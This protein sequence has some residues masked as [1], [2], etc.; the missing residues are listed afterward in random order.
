M[1]YESFSFVGVESSLTYLHCDVLVCDGSASLT[2]DNRCTRGKCGRGRK[3][4]HLNNVKEL[5]TFNVWQVNSGPFF[6]GSRSTLSHPVRKIRALKESLVDRKV[7]TKS[8]K[9]TSF[10]K[11]DEMTGK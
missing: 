5:Q 7:V 11:L 2:K 8:N 3:R 9:R 1:S 4:R 10:F 6:V